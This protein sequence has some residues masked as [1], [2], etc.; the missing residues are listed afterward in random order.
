M[1][2][3]PETALLTTVSQCQHAPRRPQV[4]APISTLGMNDISYLTS[5][6]ARS[7][8]V[9]QHVRLRERRSSALAYGR[10][11][12][13]LLERKI[14]STQAELAVGLEVSKGH[15]SKALK[16]ARLPNEV[17]RTFGASDRVSFRV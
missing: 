1:P 14:W 17:L 16:A 7:D 8:A 9:N 15:I 12:L 6:N 10:F 5:L 4:A 2:K 13:D 3:A 11:Y